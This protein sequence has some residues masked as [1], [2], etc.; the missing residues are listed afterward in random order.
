MHRIRKHASFANVT[1]LMALTVA[2]GGTAYAGAALTRNSVGSAQLKPAA[3]ATSD[4]RNN[5]VTSGKVRNGTLRLGDIRSADRVSLRGPVGP[6]GARGATGATGP[7]GPA[8]ATGPTG[9]AGAPGTARAYARI[10]PTGLLVGGAAQNKGIVQ[11]NIRHTELAPPDGTQ[12]TNTG[13]GVYCIGGLDFTV[14]SASVSTDNTDA[15]PAVP[16]LTGGALNVIPTAAVFKGEEFSRCPANFEQVRVAMQQ[17]ND[18]AAPTLV[19]HGFFI[20]LEG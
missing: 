12:T 9:P 6:T 8:G 1:S 14:T 4:L 7:Q 15:M 5:S 19:N 20:W 16:G 10:G 2:L 11:A 13:V 18:T 3:V 17:V